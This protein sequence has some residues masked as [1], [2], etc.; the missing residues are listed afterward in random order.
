M[1]IPFSRWLVPY[2]VLWERSLPTLM[3]G[4]LATSA[5]PRPS[6]RILGW[7][8]LVASI[9]LGFLHA[10]A[11]VAHPAV[12]ATAPG[13]L[14]RYRP[15]VVLVGFR[16]GVSW[17][18]REAVEHAVGARQHAPLDQLDSATAAARTLKRR[19]GASFVLDV[20]PGSVMATVRA[21]QRDVAWVRYAEPDY[22]LGA[23]GAGAATIPTDPSFDLQWGSHNTGQTVNGTTGTPGADD[24]ATLAWSLTTGSRSIVIGEPDTGVD[25]KH[26]DLGSNIWTNP[27]G[28]GGCASGTRGFDVID[29]TTPCDP[30]DGD[31]D[32]GGHGTHVAG[33]M[34]AVGNNGAGVAGM[35]WSTT[36]LPVKWLS[37]ESTTGYTD[38]LI[39]AL[40]KLLAAK[41]AGVNI[42]VVNDSSVYYGTAYSQALSDEIDA[43]GAGDILFVTAAGNSGQNMD[44][45]SQ[46]VR[47]PCA[48]DRP[49]EICVTASDQNDNL[50]SSG[51]YG[52]NYAPDIVDLAAPGANIYSTLRN[53]SYGY[54][55]GGSMAAAQVS[56]AAALILSAKDMSTTALKAD[57]I[58]NVDQLPSLA[59]KV[60]TGARIDDSPPTPTSPP[61]PP[62]ID[63][64]P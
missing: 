6:P 63:S 51:T 60:R 31:T 12:T 3:S 39:A 4:F 8:L 36:I 18:R 11:A 13:Q 9:A 29:S 17:A 10:D 47:Y 46:W 20:P 32:Y 1:K 21:L 43:L 37:T 40:D 52:A 28:I 59:G 64:V 30:M 44:L 25:Y 50:W 34:G 19:I 57:I 61:P 41:Q 16:P 58:D 14:P 27:G 53:G 42:R 55:S 35:N 15:G 49:T 33:I 5:R 54:I 56:G 24:K 38:Q 45:N 7:L 22:L 26:P 48:Y 62:T 2:T 23:S